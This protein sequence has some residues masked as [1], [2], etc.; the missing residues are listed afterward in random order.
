MCECKR[1]IP[2]SFREVTRKELNDLLKVPQAMPDIPDSRDLKLKCLEVADSMTV[3][4]PEEVLSFA[5]QIYE[6]VK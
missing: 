4:T 3:S 1:P 6:W 2:G 5:K